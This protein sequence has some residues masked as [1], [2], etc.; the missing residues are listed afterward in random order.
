MIINKKQLKR[1]ERITCQKKIILDYLKSVKTHPSAEMIFKEVRRKLPRI[2]QG[3]VYRIINNLKNKGEAQAISVGG[4]TYF[5]GDTYSHTHF[6]CQ[7]CGKIFDISDACK[8]CQ[9]IKR[10]R[11]KFGKIQKYNIYFYGLCKNC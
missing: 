3:T 7:K 6:I 4:I 10:K 9:V 11:V 5:D 2:S 8:K 1:I